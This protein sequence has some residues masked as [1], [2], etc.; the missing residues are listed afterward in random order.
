MRKYCLIIV[1]LFAVQLC[2]TSVIPMSVEQMTVAASHVL[3][4]RAISSEAQWNADH[5]QIFTYTR[6]QPLETLKG[7]AS[8]EIVVRQMGGRVGTIE[9]KVS[10]VR[11]WRTGDE[12]VLFLRPSEVGNGV[13]AVVGLFQ[14]NFA[15]KRTSST[16]AIA[17]NGVEDAM[18]FDPSTGTA[19]H[20]QAAQ[21]SLTELR[22][23]VSRVMGR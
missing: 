8:S 19:K 16:E 10:G 1:A 3:R 5:T 17:T 22:Q 12:S 4:A 18:Q 9:Q 23:R 2:A 7:A 13:M 11:R 14:G 20:Y 21:I 6:F 15:V